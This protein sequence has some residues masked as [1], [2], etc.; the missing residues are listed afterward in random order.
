MATTMDPP[1]AADVA[2]SSGPLGAAGV[3][4]PPTPEGPPHAQGASRPAG[5]GRVHR[6]WRGPDDDPRWARPALFVLLGA[7]AVLYLWGLGASGWANSF[8]SAAVQ[9]GTHSWKALFFGSSDASNSITVD[10]PPVS[11]WAMGISARIFGVNAWSILVPQ[12]LAGVAS[13][14]LLFAAVKR[15]YGAAAGLIAGAVLALTPVATLMF[16]FNNPDAV[17]VLLLIGAAYAL[18][19]SLE[20]ASTRW[21]LLAWSLVG[22]AFLTKMLQALL[23]APAFALVYLVCAP[24]PF[25]RRFVQSVHAFIALVVSAGWWIAIVELWP[26]SSRPYIGGSQENSILELVLGY[27]GLGRL[28]GNETGSVGGGGGTGMWGETGWNRMFNGEFGSQASWLLPAAFA[29]LAIGLVLR[30]R[31]ARTDRSRAAYLVWGGWLAVTTVAFSFGKGIIH[32]YYAVALAPAIGALVGMGAVD[33]WRRRTAWWARASMGLTTAGSAW[34]SYQ[35]MHRAPDWA[36]G[37]Q[38]AVLVGGLAVGALLIAAPTLTGRVGTALAISAIVVGLAGPTAY[39]LQ[40]AATTHSGSLPSAGPSASGGFG[41]P[42]GMGGFG[43]MRGGFPGGG[44]GQLPT[45]PGGGTGGGQRTGG[46]QGNA[47]G[48]LTG[49]TS[50]D[51]VTALL[52]ADAGDYTWVAA[53]VGSNSASGFQLASDE[54]VMAIG[55]FN[56][57]DPSPTLEQFQQYVADGQIHYFVSGGGFGGMGGGT[58]GSNASSEI[59]S[60]V[61]ANFTAT[62]VDGVTLYDLTASS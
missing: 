7:A 31:A 16:R 19:R 55:G 43:G 2:T 36:P 60:W 3:S 42:G 61:E 58:G 9:A 20:A 56:G 14:G 11:L 22:T 41:R 59:R 33:L 45:F 24:T 38:T 48:L 26:A 4:G 25:R 54:P 1:T 51:Q 21:L 23:V 62:T 34:W 57:S 35:L 12:A 47:G 39:S 30:G 50:S 5:R 40:T 8:Y 17:L 53:A 13:V 32:P 49:S 18:L 44:N 37:L 15:W 28:T 6:L 29:L 46:G 27:N 10:K 52:Q